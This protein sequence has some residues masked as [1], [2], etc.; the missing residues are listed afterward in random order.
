MTFQ[1][2]NTQNMWVDSNTQNMWVDLFGKSKM[3]LIGQMCKDQVSSNLSN[4][5]KQTF[6]PCNLI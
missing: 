6:T 3:F 1:N 4:H 5:N 2:S